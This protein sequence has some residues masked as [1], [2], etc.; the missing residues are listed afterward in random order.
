MSIYA[1]QNN[2]QPTAHLHRY[3]LRLDGFAS[4]HA[5]YEG[6]EVVTKL[7][8]FSGNQLLLN[9]ST[10][11]AGGIKIGISD[12][13]GKMMPGYGFGDSV[14]SIGNEIERPA[15]WKQGMDVSTLAGRPVRLHFKMKDAELYAIQFVHRR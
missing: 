8:I 15:R 1:N 3:S 7:L 13:D 9:F 2:A 14:E 12:E 5:S 4:L 11:A 10:S 6:G